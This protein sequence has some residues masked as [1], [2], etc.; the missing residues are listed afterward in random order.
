[1]GDV[2]KRTGSEDHL[3]KTDWINSVKEK[4]EYKIPLLTEWR[5][6]DLA[7]QIGSRSG[8]RPSALF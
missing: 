2:S 8:E 5:E 6:N 3:E 4:A 7:K 1:M